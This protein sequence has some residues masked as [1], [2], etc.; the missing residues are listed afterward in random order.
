MTVACGDFLGEA[1][2]TQA[3]AGG[4]ASRLG[5]CGG[6]ISVAA[7]SA[8]PGEARAACFVHMLAAAV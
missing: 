3:F 7:R 6:A 1:Q 5:L 2:R 8:G 4:W